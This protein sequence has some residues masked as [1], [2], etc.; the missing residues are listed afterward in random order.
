MAS[1]TLKG[2]PD[3][4]KARLEEIADRERRSLNQQA[5]SL[6]KCAVREEPI[7][8]DQAYQRFRE[9]QGESPLEEGNLSGL[10]SEEG[11]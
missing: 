7:G 9:K 3:D 4:L 1:I 11:A 5:I 10:R 6:L 2:L 8:F